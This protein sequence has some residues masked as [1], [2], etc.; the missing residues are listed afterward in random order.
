MAAHFDPVNLIYSPQRYY[1]NG[2]VIRDGVR[3][4]APYLRTCHAKDTLLSTQLTTHL[5]EVRPGLGNLG[6]CCVSA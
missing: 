2:K 5:S 1:G 4:L 3:R 6:L